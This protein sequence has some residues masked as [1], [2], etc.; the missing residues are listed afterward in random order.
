MITPYYPEAQGMVERGHKEIKDA[1]T[2]MCGENGNKWKE[3]LPLVTFADRIST[4]RT[5]GYSPYELQFGQIAILPVDQELGSFL[6]V[7]WSEIRK[8]AELLEARAT[9]LG[10][11]EEMMEKAYQKIK[12]ACKTSVRYWDKRLAHRLQ[13]PLTPG[14]LVLVYNKALETQWGNLFKHKWNGPFKIVKKINRGPY[15]L[16]ELDGTVLTRT[17]AASRVDGAT[18]GKVHASRR[19][20]APPG[21]RQWLAR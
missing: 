8:T 12:Q 13:K 15:V 10:A 2:K 19:L 3:Y 4:K 7:N 18:F 5:T 6:M 16:A 21:A 9:Q 14:D 11:K 20:L 1:L 17:F